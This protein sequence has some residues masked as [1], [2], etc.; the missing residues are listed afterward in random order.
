MV[1]GYHYVV[2]KTYRWGI[3]SNKDGENNILIKE[4]LGESESIYT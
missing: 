3:L 1:L 4:H 2:G